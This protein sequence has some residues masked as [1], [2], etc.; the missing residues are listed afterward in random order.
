MDQI[1]NKKRMAKM[2]QP[3]RFALS[4]LSFSILLMTQAHALQVLSDQALREVEGQDGFNA[5]INFTEAKIDKVEWI[6]QAGKPG[7]NDTGEMGLAATYSGVQISRGDL[8]TDQQL[9]AK[10]SLDVYGSE[11]STGAAGIH[12]NMQNT[13][14]KVTVDKV[15]VCA[16]DT[17]CGPNDPSMGS[18]QIE[19]YQPIVFNLLTTNG[20]FNKDSKTFLDLS[21]KDAR[22]AI[23]QKD[24]QGQQNMLSMEHLNINISTLSYLS[25]DPKNGIRLTSGSDGFA[26]FIR[27]EVT[28][29][30]GINLEFAVNNKGLIRAGANGRMVNGVVELGSSASQPGML[31]KANQKIAGSAPASKNDIAGSTGIR[32]KLAGEFTNDTDK[33]GANATS[34][35]LG[36]AGTYAY[37]LR[38]ENITAL[39]TRS[40]ISGSERDD[41]PLTTERAGLDM[42]GVYINMVNSHQ[43]LLPENQ[44]LKNT[45]FGTNTGNNAKPMVNQY[46][47]MQ[48]IG[49]TGPINPNSAVLSL[50]QVDFVALS[51]RGQFIAT[52]DVTDPTKL[53]ST[54]AA[55]WGLGLPIHNLNSN[56]AFYAK[57]SDGVK[58]FI[59]SKNQDGVPILT[60]VTGSD[61]LG[62]SAS[63][64]T[65]GVNNDGSKSTSILLIDGADN[66][67]YANGMVT[68]T[69][70]YVGLRN[71]DMLLNGYGSIGFEDGR[72]NVS[73]PDLK[74]I[75]AAQFAAGYLPGAKFK[76]CPVTGG[77]YAP[78]NSFST[79]NDVLAGFKM[80]LE[81]GINF[82]LVPRSVLSSQDGLVDGVNA[83]N[84]VGIMSLIDSNAVTNSI[85]LVDADGSTIGFDNLRGVIGFDNNI[86]VNKNNIGFHY[87]FVF[88]PNKK[89]DDVFRVKDLNLYPATTANGKT[90]VGNPQRLGEIAITGGRINAEMTITP[91]DTPF[92]F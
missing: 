58:D 70:Y 68:P 69:D 55:Q 61:R 12:F 38:F 73:L 89:K 7:V 60:P 5:D 23:Q 22:V 47:Y 72:I 43:I 37:G 50:R 90:T 26:D 52:P 13:L 85:Q 14:G 82:A 78:S 15:Q 91:R 2:S 11:Q 67:N 36:G 10:V 88:N 56:F 92:V 57:K 17:G 30:P 40:N 29:R 39:R 44:S 76:S 77:C 1:K 62:F 20:L 33:L 71:I 83:M 64:S 34:L 24:A 63:I 25:I 6:D 49:Q 18:L 16:A 9:G 21:L 59:A 19:S 41:R 54:E 4:V 75:V 27:D 32:F 31:G 3:Q 45:F 87:S 84:I 28:G 51:R 74:M 53:P 48:T 35:E 80:R 65:Q 79:N 46:D 86:I 8:A 42:D 81:G 66:T